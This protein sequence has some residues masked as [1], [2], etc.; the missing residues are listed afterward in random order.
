MKSSDKKN[1][2]GS[3]KVGPKGQIVIPKD[4]REM[5]GIEPGDTLIILADSKKG[6]ALE[7]FSIFS[8]I[9]DKIL[10]G[11]AKEMYPDNDENDSMDF[12]RAIKEVEQSDECD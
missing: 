4:V 7:R 9:A 6:I 12:A 10:G 3:V 11:H 1:Y 8:G 2:I 5:F